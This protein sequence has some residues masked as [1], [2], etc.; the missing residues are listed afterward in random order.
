[1]G[2]TGAARI[3]GWLV[4][5]TCC[6]G[7]CGFSGSS[8]KITPEHGMTNRYNARPRNCADLCAF[9]ASRKTCRQFV[10]HGKCA[11]WRMDDTNVDSALAD[12]GRFEF[13]MS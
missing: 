10:G 11:A 6:M 8:A 1:M 4:V 5:V 13:V 7:K 3:G 2:S 12:R 9:V